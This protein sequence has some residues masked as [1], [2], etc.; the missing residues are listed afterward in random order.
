MRFP[1]REGTPVAAVVS[2]DKTM[3]MVETM[4]PK[5][6]GKVDTAAGNV[7]VTDAKP[8]VMIDFYRMSGGDKAGA[9]M[10]ITGAGMVR[11]PGPMMLPMDAD[12]YLWPSDAKRGSWPVSFN[13]FGGREVKIANVDSSCPPRLQMVSRSQFVAFTCKGSEGRVNLKS[14]GLDGHETW[15]ETLTGT[16]GAPELAFAPEAGRFALSRII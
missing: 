12:G 2:P 6:K 3:V 1:T 4:A 9:P 10:T 5:Q 14:Y 8:V 15:E 11:A 16:Y 7:I 13:E